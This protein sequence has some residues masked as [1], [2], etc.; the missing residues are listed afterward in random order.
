[1]T[2][3][4]APISLG[5]YLLTRAN[6][7]PEDS[8]KF[9]KECNLIAKEHE[10]TSA[11]ATAICEKNTLIM[12]Q[13]YTDIFNHVEDWKSLHSKEQSKVNYSITQEQSTSLL[14]FLSAVTTSQELTLEE[15]HEARRLKSEL[16]SQSLIQEGKF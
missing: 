16:I 13:E 2:K 14:H 12:S 11:I 3:N 1:M 6:F 5:T 9:Q 4:K 8:D 10:L 15:K 7:Q